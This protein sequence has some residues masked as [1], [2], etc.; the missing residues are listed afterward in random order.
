M[1]QGGVCPSA[2]FKTSAL[3][4]HLADKELLLIPLMVEDE[5]PFVSFR[6][7]KEWEKNPGGTEAEFQTIYPGAQ[8]Q[9]SKL[10]IRGR[11]GRVPNYLSGGTEAEFQTLYPGG[12]EAKFQTIFGQQG[13][14]R[15]VPSSQQYLHNEL[16]LIPR[17]TLS[18][19]GVSCKCD[20]VRVALY[21]GLEGSKARTSVEAVGVGVEPVGIDY[22][23]P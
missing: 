13:A 5:S 17:F 2:I 20:S 4:K 3:I 11:R 12:T 16:P 9:S 8:R 10:S 6:S 18:P 14:Q 19:S 1:S 21:L 7:G 15:A 23:K 22:K